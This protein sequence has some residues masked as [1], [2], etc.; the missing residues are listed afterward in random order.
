MSVIEEVRREREDL[1]R[2]L[3]KHK[4]IRKLVEDLY[5]D[6][7]HFIYELLQ[8][9]EDTGA[10]EARFTLSNNNLIFEHN[11]R[12]FDLRDIYAITDIGE[13]TKTED[14]DKIGRFGIGFKAVFAYCETPQIWSP[15]FS[16]TIT[17]LVLPSELNSRPELGKRTCFEFP[18]NNPKK[19][20]EDAYAEIR[21]GLEELAETTL[22]FL[23]HLESI[24]W[25]IDRQEVREVLR[26]PHAENHVEILRQTGD[27]KTTSVHFL[28]FIDSVERL[29][30]QHVAVAF[31]L[32][33]LPNVTVYD[34]KTALAK[35]LRIIPADPGRVAVF[36]PAEN[37]TSG[38]RFHL[39]APFVTEL[40]R[41]SIKE[42]PVNDPLVQQLAELASASLHRIREL[43]LLNG[44][45]LGVLPNSQDSVPERYE[46]IRLAIIAE[47]NN[48][49]LTPTYSKSHAPAK[50]LLQA[51]VSIKKLLTDEDIKLLVSSDKQWAVAAAQKNSNADRFLAG[52]AITDWD[53]NEFVNLLV[54]QAS[55][56]THFIVT[57]PHYANGPDEEF[58]RWL[59]TKPVEWHQELYAL[60]L[61]P[62]ISSFRLKDLKIIRLSDSTYNAG[63]KKCYFPS[64]GV[65]CDES[66]PLVDAGVYTSG[67]S[68]AQQE[69]AKKLLEKLG[70]HEV[71]EADY[72]EA[73]LKQRYAGG[74]GFKPDL[75]DF[76]R[77]VALVEKEPDRAALFVGYYIFER[78]DGK[79]GLPNQVYLDTPF[80][81]TGLR[82]YYEALGEDAARMALASQY[83]ECGIS[84]SRITKFA[85]AVGVCC[86]LEIDE[87]S[88]RKHPQWENLGQDFFGYRVRW[89]DSAVDSD[90]TIKNLE[91]AL[92]NPS[93]ALS[94][95]VWNTMI[96][97]E[98]NVL[99]ARFR[100]NRQYMVRE[101]KSSLVLLLEE[102]SWIPQGGGEFVVPREASRAKL[103]AKG[104]PYEKGYGW[105]TA[106][107]FGEEE[108]QRSE[109]F[110]KK[111]SIATESGFTDHASHERALRFAAL[112]LDEQESILSERESR[113]NTDL[114]QRES[115]NPERRAKLVAE[116]A[117]NAPERLTAERTRSVPIGLEE[118]RESAKQYLRSQYS[119]IHGQMI[120]QICKTALPFTLDDGSYYFEAIV[121][122]KDLDLKQHHDQNYL[123][124]CPNHA[125]MYKYANGSTDLLRGRFIEITGN[126]IEVELARTNETIYFTKTHIA[127]LKTVIA[128]DQS[129]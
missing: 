60:L 127:D 108:Q 85:E 17:E 95:L 73:I 10:T 3:K 56:G 129:Q 49:P 86:H 22:L 74:E 54:D 45:F 41:A 27:K 128:T 79:W 30:K 107:G 81:D 100:P 87:V 124:L 40:S 53:I 32:D 96:A 20:A 9:A 33:Y 7:A 76:R 78:K 114:P 102:L 19:R 99:E 46:S 119:N 75:K 93:E 82:A 51:K 125:A 2:V 104:F 38:L 111:Q 31:E 12:P 68:K 62:N 52:L 55:E 120:C 36:F 11:G 113:T 14:E 91:K 65:E 116:Q 106:I 18:F 110:Q 77:F 6:R 72:V 24:R 37:E 44:E 123:A 98:E 97:S 57:P 71:G 115:P 5:P 61:D 94:R 92:K 23:T 26:I 109:E 16:F 90:W 84:V 42:T 21:K 8:N 64:K 50:N 39:H 101:A 13:G 103:P 122:L 25:Q 66:F 88:V 15:E 83:A 117:A 126:E 48:Q 34:T 47:M 28:R 121:F 118:V 80:R 59:A 4:G 69:D 67:R 58:M 70:V 29:Q 89:T 43:D 112:P 63:S 1:A 105:L 35:Q